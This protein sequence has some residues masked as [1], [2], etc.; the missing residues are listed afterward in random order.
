MLIFTLRSYKYFTYSFGSLVPRRHGSTDSYR[1]GF[2]GQEKDDEIKG[3][4]NSLNYTFRMHDPRVGRF[5]AI[6]PLFSDYPWNSPYAFSENRVIDAVE[7]EGL[8]S[9]LTNKL[10]FG[11]TTVQK[12]QN[13]NNI[14]KENKVVVLT[15]CGLGVGA[16]SISAFG[17]VA[18]GTYIA[19]EGAEYAF[20]EMTGIP[21]IM[22]PIDALEQIAKKGG[23]KF[24]KD[25]IV[26]G[27]KFASGSSVKQMKNW[28][29]NVKTYGIKAAKDFEAGKYS[30]SSFK[31]AISKSVEFGA[32]NTKGHLIK[33]A[34]VFG[35][36][37]SAQELQKMIPELQEA[38]SNFAKNADEIRI[39]KW[40]DTFDDVTFYKKGNDYMVK[41]NKTG[42]FVTAGKG[43][44]GNKK[45]NAATAVKAPS[46]EK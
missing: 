17:I 26:E 21:V 38:A 7:L 35:L 44:S 30:I 6:D 19:E 11:L 4:G 13:F 16:A 33:H 23:K 29:F 32:K 8:E 14:I 42:N 43:V 22:D 20:E 45:Y 34:D 1:Y 24:A 15:V 12:T 25:V 41:D 5:F 36:D 31:S 18:V 3:E 27:R 40:D 28:A 9:S 10:D 37:K 2:Q 39:G 46:N